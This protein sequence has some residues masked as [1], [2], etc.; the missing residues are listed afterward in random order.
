VRPSF[1]SGTEFEA[2]LKKYNM[3]NLQKYRA[4]Q[5]DKFG[6]IDV[7]HINE[8]DLPAPG[9]GQVLVRVK[10]AGINPGESTIRNGVFAKQWPSI[11]PS[12]QG[13]DFAG[14]VERVGEHVEAVKKGDEVI[15]FTDARSSQ[16]EYVIAEEGHL[17]R[18][19]EH[20]PWEQAGSLFV[21][22]TT[23][24]AAVKAVSLKKG[25]ILVVS[26]AAGGVGSVVVQLAVNMGARVIGIASEANHGWLTKHGVIPV[27]YGMDLAARIKT[28]AGRHVDAFIDCY[29]QGYV[30]LALQLGVATDRID[31]II[32]FEAAKK[33]KV[34]TDGNS[35]GAKAEVLA[36]LA[37]LVDKGRLEIPIAGVYPLDQVRKAYEE[38]EK[39]HTHGK[40][41]LVP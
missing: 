31:T 38:L 6:G 4:V 32:D 3:E 9:I 13:S 22:G 28:A 19:P 15:G 11:F 7:L 36:E 17:V 30:D 5:Y 27:S 34:K 26:G 41:V 16:A 29:G 2:G 37:S 1:L 14:I 23:G 21:V 35:A 18:K 33:Y 24:Y 20:V 39:R 8:V 10:A 12:G 25:D 40:I